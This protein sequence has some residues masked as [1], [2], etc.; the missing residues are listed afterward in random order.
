MKIDQ[1]S[2]VKRALRW[3]RNGVPVDLTGAKARMEIRTSA[4]GTLLHRLDTINGGLVLG[5]T[6][7]TIQILI[8]AAASTA[9]GTLQG[10][11]DLEVIFPD[12]TVTRLI[13]GTVAIS[14]EV[15]TG[16]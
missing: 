13:Q 9:W 10:V 2:T 15:T 3:L 11:Y 5:G 12:E 1:G 14:A 16:E 6:D 8:P 7:G 4:G